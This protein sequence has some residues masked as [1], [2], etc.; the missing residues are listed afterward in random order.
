MLFVGAPLQKTAMICV[1]DLK[2]GLSNRVVGNNNPVTYTDS[3]GLKFQVN[4]SIAL[5]TRFKALLHQA[6]GG[7]LDI[8]ID[9]NN[10][11]NVSG[12]AEGNPIAQQ[13]LDSVSNGSIAQL[14]LRD[15]EGTDFGSFLGSKVSG[16]TCGSQRL[17][18]ADF[19]ALSATGD[20][21]KLYANAILAH[22]LA[23]AQGIAGFKGDPSSLE[24]PAGYVSNLPPNVRKGLH[25]HVNAGYEAENAYFKFKKMSTRRTGD[26]RGPGTYGGLQYND[27]VLIF[28]K[29]Q[30]VVSPSFR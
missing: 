1:S 9:K 8:S 22:E 27:G 4:G 2:A 5:Q 23:E 3:T 20:K 29:S 11:L 18:L 26:Y 7:R 14:S 30:S 25:F 15:G 13:L 17:D 12:N 6:T 16:V 19:E 10:F 28:D 21:G 24:I